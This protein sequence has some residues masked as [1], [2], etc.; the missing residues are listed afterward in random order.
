MNGESASE[1]SKTIR[2]KPSTLARLNRIKHSGQSY[3]G[4]ITEVLDFYEQKR[5]IMRPSLKADN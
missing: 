5:S 1:P 4:I 3:D 2:L